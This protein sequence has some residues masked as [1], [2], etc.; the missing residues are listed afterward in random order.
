MKNLIISTL[1]LY[2]LVCSCTSLQAVNISRESGM[3]I[4][5][6][7]SDNSGNQ[8]GS[9]FNI[10]E[11]TIILGRINISI[12]NA[13]ANLWNWGKIPMGYEL[14]KNG[15]LTELADQEWKPGI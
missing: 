11:N 3:A 9:N 12:D 4:L 10:T 15:T 7:V 6:N 13:S 14:N 2:T 8:S 1:I 5:A